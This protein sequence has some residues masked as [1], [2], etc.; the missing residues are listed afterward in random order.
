MEL[1]IYVFLTVFVLIASSGLILAISRQK[2]PSNISST[3]TA[4]S[5]PDNLVQTFHQASASL[6]QMVGRFERV[7]PKSKAEFSQVQNRL[8]RAGYRK[9]SAVK[10]YYG[11]KVVLPIFLSFWA[12]V[13]VAGL[14]HQRSLF[15]YILTCV[16]GF[17]APDFWLTR[18]IA[19]RQKQIRL[20]LPD[21]LDMLVICVEAGL[22]LDQ[23]MV[24]TSE[25]L[26]K[27]HAAIG[28]E[29]GIVILE[30]RA[31]IP[32]SEA[33]KNL[34]ERTG[35][36][37]VRNFVSTLVQSEQFGTSIAK[38]LRVHSETLRT[39]RVQML[40]EQAAKTSVKMVF[41]LVI[42]IFPSLFLVTLGPALIRVLESLHHLSSN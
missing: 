31:G 33:W 40:Q 13:L 6:S 27:V 3:I 17:V 34:V 12:L 4:G 7:L 24:R 19:R 14:A 16:F 35:V 39:K 22:S 36:E 32:R 18:Q 37:S 42:F 41:P 5:G 1:A 30:Q 8:V 29:L 23:A 28:D 10:I 11:A 38:T 25:E 2:N 9:D 20:S 21:A 26:N 15:V